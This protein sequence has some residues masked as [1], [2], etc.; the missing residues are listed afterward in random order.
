M[1]NKE[2]SRRK[3]ISKC[4][5]TGSI[6]LGAGALILSSC[7]SNKSSAGDKKMSSAKSSCDDLSGVSK[8]EIE[9]RQKFAYVDKSPV[10]GNFCVNC[11]LYVPQPGNAE[12]GGCM[13]FKGP[14]RAAG[15]C[16]QYVAKE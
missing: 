13:L 15:Y 6:F 16:I 10:P 11:S 8:G 9:K 2:Y 1:K 7:D 12:C 3:F 4:F 5:G 14:V